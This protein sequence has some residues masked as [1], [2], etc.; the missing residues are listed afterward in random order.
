M[1]KTLRVAGQ[2]LR[3][4]FLEELKDFCQQQPAPSRTAIARH[5]CRELGWNNSDGQPNVT[6]ARAILVKLHKVG[7]VK[8]P[9]A[10][11]PQAGQPRRL[12]CTGQSLPAVG[13]VPARVDQ[14]QG[15]YLHRLSGWEDPLSCLWNELIVQQHPLRD[16]PLV[17]RQLRYLIGSAHGWLGAIGFGP[18]AWH[19][20]PRDQWIGWNSQARRANLHRVIG[21]SRLLIRT[22]VRCLNLASKVMAMSLRGVV[23]DWQQRYGYKP[24]LVESFIDRSQ[25]TGKSYRA[26]NWQLIGISQGRGRKGPKTGDPL[27]QKDIYV[28]AL[29]PRAR[30]QLQKQPVELV[31]ARSLLQGLE[32]D[33]W[34]QQEMDGLD[35]GDERLQQRAVKILQGR[36]NHPEKSYAQSFPDWGQVLGAYRLLGHDCEQIDL[37]ALLAAHKERTSER[38]AAEPLVLLAQDTTSL[39]YSGLKKTQGL[40][41]INHEGSLGLHL[42]STLAMNAAGV[43]LGVVDAQC[44]GREPEAEQT[45][46]LG[47]NAK[48]VDQKESVRW[49][50]SINRAAQM[51]RRMPQTTVV[52]LGDRESDIYEVFDQVLIGPE[53]L[54]VVVRAQHNR[55]LQEQAKL[56]EYMAGQPVGGQLQ[57]Q[58]PRRAGCSAR[59]ALM[60]VRWAEVH[61][62]ASAVRLK[63]HWPALKLYAVWVKEIDPPPG[64][65]PLEWMLLS[66]LPVSGWQEAVQRVQWYCLRWRIEEW[67]RVLKTGCRV[68][69]REFQ[70]ALHLQRALAFDLIVAWRT[71]MLIKLN[72]QTPNL[73]AAAVFSEAELAIL[74]CYKK[75]LMTRPTPASDKRP[76]GWHDWEERY[77]ARATASRARR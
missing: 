18:P 62:C 7:Q 66:D 52:E 58:V 16:A 31:Q 33:A 19:L 38:M 60:E 42:H 6:K 30:E 72:R 51:A 35:L 45:P 28:Y 3:V 61:I 21:L 2:L 29:Q 23:E 47:R 77:Y 37:R 49:V 39:N 53:N 34:A 56:W 17:G 44:W 12:S 9:P 74:R 14:I 22:E 4:G 25:F 67:H 75:K 40:G 50:N 11:G 65:A 13:K 20:Q 73:P 68:E 55:T 59:K 24:L 64:E 27:K 71:C 57:L 43:P 54:H 8:W 70:S 69:K 76:T 1:M 41:K 63:R 32:S 10:R 26:A 5:L 46:G 36:W 48:S 15:L